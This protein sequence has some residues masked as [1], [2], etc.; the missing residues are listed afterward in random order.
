MD[1]IFCAMLHALYFMTTVGCGTGTGGPYRTMKALRGAT[2]LAFLG[3]FA[4]HIAFTAIV[5]GQA[6]AGSAYPRVLRDFLAWYVAVVNDPLMGNP[7]QWF[8]S[9]IVAEICFQLPFFFVACYHLSRT[10]GSQYTRRY[11]SWF[12][13]ACIAYGAHTATTMVP[14]LTALATNVKAT[15][16]ERCVILL[17][18]LPYLLFPLWILGIA[19]SDDTVPVPI[20]NE[21]VE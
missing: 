20:K 3:F 17:V 2:R 5:D 13:S 9:L 10:N 1:G 16:T 12:R 7:P 15:A 4:S 14:I 8:Q 21:K 18:Y 11:P 6:L 19:V